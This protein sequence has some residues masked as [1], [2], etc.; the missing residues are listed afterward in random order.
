M[1]VVI[2][3]GFGFVGKNI[4]AVLSTSSKVDEVSCLSRQNGF[5][6]LK[7]DIDGFQKN[8]LLNADFIIN[9]A[10]DVGSL[11]YVTE[12]AGEIISINSRLIL[13]LY[14]IIQELG[15]KAL[16]INPIANCGFP[17]KLALYREED[18]WS[19]E[20][21]KSVLAYGATR[22][23]LTVIAECYK[24]QFGIQSINY[25]VPNMYGEFDS[26]DPN[27]SH[28]LNAL[29][30]KVIKAR[31]KNEDL[32]V[33]G[34]GNPKREWLYARDFGRIIYETM[35]KYQNGEDLSETI[36][37]GQKTGV[38]INYLLDIIIPASGFEGLITHDLERQDG[39]Q[40]KV[41][42]NRI[43]RKRFPDFQFTDLKEGSINTI[44]Y[45]ESVYPY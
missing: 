22:R 1:K 25:Y 7:A 15:A 44:K 17:G 43:F 6:L 28:A 20:I 18:F 40:S 39:A 41:M 30:A 3:G 23:L 34:T 31:N 13:N 12:K 8:I 32:V 33:W 16:I 24:M 38:S 42:D 11:N 2:I 21:H 9:C 36:N 35:V 10:A 14:S 4:H 29:I 27:K 19:G 5:D 26:T 45:Y 37:V